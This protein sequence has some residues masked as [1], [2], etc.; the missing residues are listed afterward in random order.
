MLPSDRALPISS[1]AP[2]TTPLMR[3]SDCSRP[4]SQEPVPSYAVSCVVAMPTTG[5]QLAGVVPGPGAGG[6][7]LPS[8]DSIHPAFT[9]WMSGEKPSP[10][11]TNQ[12][13]LWATSPA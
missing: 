10:A 7:G 5:V 3:G 9:I 4:Q 13:L 8:V 1:M 6:T 11:S 2:S 12:P